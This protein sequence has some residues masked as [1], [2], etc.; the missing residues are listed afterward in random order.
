MLALYH[1]DFRGPQRHADARAEERSRRV[2]SFEKKFVV[3]ATTR[4]KCAVSD[5]V[6]VRDAST[7]KNTSSEIDIGL[8]KKADEWT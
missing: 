3:V 5:E 8:K 6:A 4:R 1:G 2:T 7:S